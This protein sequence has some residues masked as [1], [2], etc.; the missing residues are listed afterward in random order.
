MASMTCHAQRPSA[1]VERFAPLIRARGLVLDLA[2]GTGR[3]TRY[4]LG[5]G[6]RAV[7]ADIDVSGVADLASRADVEIVEADL[8]SGSWPFGPGQ[9]DAIVVCNYLHRPHLPKLPGAL[10]PGGVLIFETFARGNE[11]HGRPR[12]PD[13]LLTENELIVA[14]APELTIVAYEHGFERE[15][16]PAVRQRI[17]AIRAGGPSP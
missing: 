3:H 4:L 7:A 12:N 11:P 2:C 14:F 17:C 9:F 6:H 16:R 5:L 15:P 8:E 10:S 1:W 13:F